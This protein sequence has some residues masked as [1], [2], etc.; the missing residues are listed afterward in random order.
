MNDNFNNDNLT[1]EFYKNKKDKIDNFEVNINSDYNFDLIEESGEIENIT[2]GKHGGKDK[3]ALKHKKFN[4]IRKEQEPISESN[5]RF[6]KTIYIFMIIS[7]CAILGQGVIFGSIDMLAISR[8]EDTA[9]V[10]IP[11][12][13]SKKEIADI[14]YNSGVINQKGAF[15]FYEV[16]FKGSKNVIPGV[17]EI[18]TNMDYEAIYSYL[19]SNANRVDTDVVDVM[20]SEGKNTREIAE[21]L[22]KM[23][24]CSAKDFLNECN[25]TSFDK[26]YPFLTENKK[27]NIVYKLEGYLFPDTYKFYK[28][29]EAK[30]AIKKFLSNYKNKINKKE[31]MEQGKEKISINEQSEQ[32]GL[33]M[34]DVITLASLVQAEAADEEDMYTVASILINRL[35]TI[36]NGGMSP[37]GDSINGCLCVDSSVWYP[38]RNRD[39]VPEEIVNNYESFYDTYK[40]K[41]LPPGPI[42]NPGLEAIK[43]TLNCKKTDYYFFCYSNNGKLYCAKTF[44]EHNANLKKAGLI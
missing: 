4:R 41:G 26:E 17:F 3:R 34:S 27:D 10:K 32:K 37:F 31:E 39:K 44:N 22:E 18:K 2:S 5:A 29:I 1:E 43:A 12:G 42:C 24:I 8:N 35:D 21:L 9:I 11:K 30:V 19:Q 33:S 14:L 38:Y 7:I 13:A 28:N 20:V 25:S 36:K 16:V 40:F 23:E 15:Y 6:F